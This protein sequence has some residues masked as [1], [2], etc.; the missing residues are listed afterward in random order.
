MV[1]PS[2]RT[3]G[4]IVLQLFAIPNPRRVKDRDSHYT[5]QFRSKKNIPELSIFH[6]LR[7]QS[8]SYYKLQGLGLYSKLCRQLVRKK[9]HE[10]TKWFRIDSLEGPVKHFVTTAYWSRKL[11]KMAMWIQDRFTDTGGQF[12]EW[13]S[14]TLQGD[15]TLTRQIL[16]RGGFWNWDKV[17]RKPFWLLRANQHKLCWMMWHSIHEAMISNKYLTCCQQRIQI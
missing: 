15:D 3:D 4:R 9:K 8:S 14:I 11:R 2:Y 1:L 16:E 7:L 10:F 5:V 6:G 13:S 12:N 17:C